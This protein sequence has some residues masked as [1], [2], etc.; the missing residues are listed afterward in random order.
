M[1]EGLGS[2]LIWTNSKGRNHEK[3]GSKLT[4]GHQGQKN[5]GEKIGSA[6]YSVKF[7]K[8]RSLVLPTID[9]GGTGG[10]EKTGEE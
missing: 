5:R 1:G 6:W 7:G 8:R 4:N 3:E 2:K 10:K 9:R